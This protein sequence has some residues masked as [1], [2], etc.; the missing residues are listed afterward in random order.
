MIANYLLVIPIA[1]LLGSIPSGYLAGRWLAGIDI[2][3]HGSGSTGATNVL[4]H[5]GKT[6]ALIVFLVDVFKG[7]AAVLVAKQLLGGDAHGWLVAAGLLALAGHIWPIWLKGK[8]GK[9]VATGLGMLLGL[10][11]AVGLASLGIFL[12]VLSFSRI[13]SLSSVVAALA[14]PALIW[15]AGYSQTTAYMGLGVLA[16]LLV[17]WRH[18]GNIKRLLAGTEPKIGKRSSQAH[19]SAPPP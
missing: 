12:L 16:A 10:L 19:D 14:L 15:I 6:P 9:A 3:E 5:V 7:S 4:R 17:V 1:Y 8:G 13:V 2:R 18:R 11:P